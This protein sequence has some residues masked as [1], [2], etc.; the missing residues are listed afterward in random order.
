VDTAVK[1]PRVTVV[2]I[3]DP[4]DARAGIEFL[5]L[6]AVQLRS[7]PFRVRRVIVQFDKATVVFHSTNLRLRA[8]TRV[9]GDLL[10]YVT[11]GAQARGTVNGLRVRPGLLLAVEPGAEATFVTDSGWAD[12]V[13][14]LEPAEVRTHLALRQPEPEFRLP[15]GVEM[16]QVSAKA[17]VGLFD[18]GRRLVNIAEAHPG[19]FN[20]A[21]NA[22]GAAEA[23]L[24]E[25][26]LAALSTASDLQPDR[27]D[28]RRRA[29]T[30]LVKLVEHSVLADSAN[31][32]TV[33]DLCRIA[34]V[35]E[36]T[37]QHA[38]KDAMGLTPLA[39]LILV[40]LHR[41]RQALKAADRGSTTVAAEAVKCSFW[42]FGE[43]SRTYKACFGET[44][45]QTLRRKAGDLGE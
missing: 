38:F 28:R 41:V 8:R 34:E 20:E 22:R 30:D 31:R 17:G 14:L 33:T 11:F 43:F 3:T 29:R 19:L 10:A 40:R 24:L 25:M 2:E 18:W 39:Y 7:E 27:D 35:S 21:I 12:I 45:S 26:L 42:H 23:E 32:L 6:D 15:Q 9:Q 13:F 16:L 1:Q 36:R 44:P 37:L 4:A 5:D